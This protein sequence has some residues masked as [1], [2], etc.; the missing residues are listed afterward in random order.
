VVARHQGETAALVSHAVVN[1]VLLCATLGL[2]N[3]HFWRVHQD[4]C[5]V[6]VF[7]V[8]ENG[9]TILVLM[10]DTSHLRDLS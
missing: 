4:T 2:A 8:K 5:A 6:N 7:D 9:F 3:D 10:N 1:R